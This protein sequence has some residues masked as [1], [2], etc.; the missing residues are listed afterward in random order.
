MT[1]YEA[2]IL[3]QA[4]KQHFTHPKYNYF[5]YN[6]K[7]N[8]PVSTFERRRDRYYYVKLS[9]HQD[10]FNLILSQF[11]DTNFNCWVGDLFKE[12]VKETYTSF[13]KR[14][15]SLG[16]LVKNEIESIPD[17]KTAFSCIGGQHPILLQL[18]RRKKVSP[19]TLVVLNKFTGMFEFWLAGVDET[20]YWPS[21]EQKLRKYEPFVQIDYKKIL[22][23]VKHRIQELR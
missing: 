22:P 16:Y 9:K 13:K 3:F 11:V 18:Y 8:I 7:I 6:G 12:D 21:I 14:Q 23:I 10:P 1:S 20:V 2:F 17:F 5:K 4:L 19:E 15:E